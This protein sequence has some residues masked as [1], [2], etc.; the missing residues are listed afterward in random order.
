MAETPAEYN[1]NVIGEFRAN[2]GRVGGIWE[3]TPLLLL[4]HTGAKS[5]MSRVNPVAYLP[6]D[7]GYLILAANGGAP[8]NPAWY[9]NLKTHPI[10]RIE[11]GGEKIDVVAEEATGNERDRLFARA[12]EHYP[13]PAEIARKTERVIPMTVLM[14]RPNT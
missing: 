13:Q 8:K 5:G 1:A 9:H 10:T 11:V 7:A 14:P 2:S 4:H 6:D 12:A 3:G